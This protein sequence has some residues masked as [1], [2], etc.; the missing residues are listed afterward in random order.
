MQPMKNLDERLWFEK[1]NLIRSHP[2]RLE[3]R[4]ALKGEIHFLFLLMSEVFTVFITMALE[5]E[6]C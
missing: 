6:G 3:K 1:N 2:E 5:R 4:R